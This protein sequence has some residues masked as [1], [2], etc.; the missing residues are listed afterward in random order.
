MFLMIIIYAVGRRYVFEILYALLRV[1][2]RL[3]TISF[4]GKFIIFRSRYNVMT[5]N[6]VN[7]YCSMFFP[8]N[9][10]INSEKKKN[11]LNCMFLRKSE[12]RVH[13][14]TK[15]PPTPTHS[16]DS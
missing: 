14:T 12:D 4:H 11:K 2:S 1:P 7:C 16:H 9:I 5:L 15:I 13:S 10:K 3:A 6:Y 8:I